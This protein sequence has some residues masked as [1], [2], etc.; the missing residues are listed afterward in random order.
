M[1]GWE[2]QRGQCDGEDRFQ[3]EDRPAEG[4]DFTLP[5]DFTHYSFTSLSFSM[6]LSLSFS[7]LFLSISSDFL[8]FHL[9]L[10]LPRSKNSEW[11][12]IVWLHHW[13]Q[14]WASALKSLCVCVYE[15]MCV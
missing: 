8:S 14:E 3:R 1:E 2:E 15:C 4:E 7:L 13:K 6:T 11:R 5:L 12:L 9:F 10:V